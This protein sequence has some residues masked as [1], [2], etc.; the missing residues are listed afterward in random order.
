MADIVYTPMKV[1]GVRIGRGNKLAVTIYCVSLLE[2]TLF[3]VLFRVVLYM[4]T[5]GDGGSLAHMNEKLV[6]VRTI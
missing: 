1:I 2:P 4:I 6:T 3:N 5:N